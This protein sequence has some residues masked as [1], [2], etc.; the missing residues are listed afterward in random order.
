MRNPIRKRQRYEQERV[1][2][3]NHAEKGF[4]AEN[5][6]YTK[7][8]PQMLTI[9]IRC[10]D[11]SMIN[12]GV[13]LVNTMCRFKNI[14]QKIKKSPRFRDSKSNTNLVTAFHDMQKLQNAA[15]PG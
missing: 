13:R 7:C 10:V 15:V 9:E 2:E 11:N 8:L 5:N 4:C 14:L 12:T 3:I 6:L 1:S